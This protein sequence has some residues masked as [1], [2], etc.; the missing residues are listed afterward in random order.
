MVELTQHI[1]KELALLEVKQGIARSL[2][3]DHEE[4]ITEMEE[5]NC[6]VT[7]A[8]SRQRVNTTIE[9]NLKRP[10]GLGAPPSVA[11]PWS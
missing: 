7:S 2:K 1:V 10:F 5:M 6:V 3:D 9:G 8:G 4:R 11:E